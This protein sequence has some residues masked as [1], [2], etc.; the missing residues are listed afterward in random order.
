MKKL[1][2][3]IL[4]ALS[5][6]TYGQLSQ[7][8]VGTSANDGTGE[9][10]RSAFQ[11][12][13]LGITQINTNTGNI[14][15]KLAITDT[16]NMLLRYIN[17]A[18][19][20]AMLSPYITD[21]EAR[22]AINDS[23]TARL[24]GATEISDIAVMLAD[25]TG[26]APGNYVTRKALSDSI[27][28]NAGSVAGITLNSGTL[29]LTGG[30][31]LT[32][33]TSGNYTYTLPQSSGG[34]LML[35]S[36][37]QAAINDSLEARL[38]DAIDI[39]TVL[40]DYEPSLGNPASDGY[41]LSST[42]AGV[43][44]WVQ[45]GAGASYDS[46]YI[47]YRVDSLTTV[48]S[49]LQSELTSLIDAINRL[50][51][52]DITPPR[53]LS[54]EIGTY[55]DSIVVMIMDTTDIQQDSVPLASHFALTEGGIGVGIDTVTINID[56][57]FIALDS[58][59]TAGTTLLL[60]YTSGYPALQDSSGNK[61][62][63]WENK[64]VTNNITASTLLNG[65]VGYWKLDETEGTTA[66]D[67]TANNLD[68][69]TDATI[70]QT[71]KIGKCYSFASGQEVGMGT[72]STLKPTAGLSISAWFQQYL[73][74][75]TIASNGVINGNGWAF[76][77]EVSTGFPTFTSYVNYS[78]QKV[79][80]ATSVTTGSPLVWH[81]VVFTYDGTNGRIYVDGELDGGPTA[82]SN[83]LNYDAGSVFQL[84]VGVAV[85]GQCTGMIDEVLIYDRA[86]TADEVT[87][88]YE[89][90]QPL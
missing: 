30:D 17:K 58:T 74:Q 56:T 76:Y 75:G 49:N 28:A 6:I 32:F 38:I 11:K 51:L 3:L 82:L 16:T 24:N 84:G 9:S 15:L 67:E 70:N 46:T 19:T 79:T 39:S 85:G 60:D 47:H 43:R 71:G 48:V 53:F 81:H 64:V 36:E 62:V 18:D 1:I 52:G 57:V 34:T 35:M 42:S 72:S 66:H 20:A 55:S 77:T 63:S 31:A 41:V 4:L 90:T 5:S 2:I 88:L 65:L 27:A 37:I 33:E 22:N 14:A 26:N 87:D 40:D 21:I 78:E 59:L 25:S 68:G 10:L 83:G 44:S 50:D 61:T 7:I 29:T 54:A 13:N 12:V 23:L 89:L 86:L 69:T 45:A 8:N 73:Y 80:G